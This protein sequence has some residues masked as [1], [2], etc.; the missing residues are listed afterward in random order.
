MTGKKGDNKPQYM[1]KLGNKAEKRKEK[2]K[3]KEDK[4]TRKTLK[5][6]NWNKK[7]QNYS[8]TTNWMRQVIE[9]LCFFVFFF[10]YYKYLK[11]L[12]LHLTDIWTHVVFKHTLNFFSSLALRCG[13]VVLLWFKQGTSWTNDPIAFAV[14]TTTHFLIQRR[15]RIDHRIFHQHGNCHWTHTT[16]YWSNGTRSFKGGGVINITCKQ[17]Q[18]KKRTKDRSIKQ[19]K[20]Q[21][22]MST[23]S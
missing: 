16:R 20:L 6:T 2:N 4:T 12:C 23:N 22:C 19:Q 17:E 15:L 1:L 5:T 14:H 10:Y 18:R 8:K 3:S 9:F 13:F 7:K 21:T 11:Y